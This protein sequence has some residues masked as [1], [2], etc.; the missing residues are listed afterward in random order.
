MSEK[1]FVMEAKRFAQKR[2]KEEYGFA[3]ET[4]KIIVMEEEYVR[5]P[6]YILVVYAEVTVNGKHYAIS[7]KRIDRKEERDLK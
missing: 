5:M 7:N 3:P 4:N 1:A 6:G 2:L